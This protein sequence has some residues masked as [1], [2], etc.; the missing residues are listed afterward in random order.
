MILYHGTS[1]VFGR[2]ILCDEKILSNTTRN[3][4]ET[5]QLNNTQIDITTTNGYVYLTSSFIRAYNYGNRASLIH[6]RQPHIYIFKLQVN[7]ELLLPD[8]DER[9]LHSEDFN[10]QNVSYNV[11]KSLEIYKGVCVA[12]NLDLR[13]TLIEYTKLPVYDIFKAEGNE[14]YTHLIGI[15][16]DETNVRINQFVEQF[17]CWNR[18]Y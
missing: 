2:K 4:S 5:L 16:N 13:D 14:I 6:N 9:R 12:D 7:D 17:G 3:Y 8:L 1:E 18:K 11:Q 10:E 15:R